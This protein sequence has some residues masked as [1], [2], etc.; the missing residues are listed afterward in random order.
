MKRANINLML[1]TGT[2]ALLAA[3]GGESELIVLVEMDEGIAHGVHADRHDHDHDHDHDH[4]HDH[5]T[6]IVDGWDLEFSEYVVHFGDVTIAKSA[7]LSGVK[8]LPIERLIDLKRIGAS[9][10]L[11]ML[12]GLESGRWD[13]LSWSVAPPKEASECHARVS[14]ALCDQMIEG[15]ESVYLAGTLKNPSGRSCPPGGEEREA[16]EIAFEFA[17]PIAVRFA[18]CQ[19]AG[20]EGVGLPSGGSSAI[21]LS[22]HAEHLLFNAF[23]EGQREI[24]LRAQYLANA[25]LDGDGKVTIEELRAIKESDFEP[26]FTNCSEDHSLVSFSEGYSLSGAINDPI[27]TLEDYLIAHLMTQGHVDGEHECAALPL[28]P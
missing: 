28:E 16:T 6:S 19:S 2:L 27:E 21:A 15:G 25:D 8:I 26:L 14:Q 13:R 7:D 22:Y 18:E 17:L 4:G 1:L 23:A 3:C 24:R 11:G 20:G 9:E 10:E 12:G 5:P